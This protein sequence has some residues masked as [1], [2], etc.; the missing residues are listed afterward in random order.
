M[1]EPS[2]LL[3]ILLALIG[4]VFGS[5]G[6]VLIFRLPRGHSIGGRSQCMHCGWQI[7]PLEL[8][9]VVSFLLLRGRC[10]GCKERISLQYP[11]VETISA[12]IVLFA[13]VSQE[14]VLLPSALLAIAL[15]VLLLIAVIDLRE[16]L[17]PDVLNIPF[18]AFAILWRLADQSFSWGGILVGL[19][20]IGSQWALSRGKWMG[21]GDV[22]LA[23]GLGA[24]VGDSV[25]GLIW[26]LLS[27]MI[28]SVIASVLLL[29][30]QK[31]TK[32]L[33]SFAP[34][35][36]LGAITTLILGEPLRILL[37]I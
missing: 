22:I 19:I 25:A 36:A 18:V 5:F 8:I 33:I 11:L 21:S 24:L 14:F 2:V 15:W 9:P 31:T 29:T 13:F 20:I 35:L 3:Y 34:F 30:H 23:V 7:R 37:N 4:L 27:Y 12:A 1:P 16:H 10:R 26:I 28:G 17:I 32:D 6:N